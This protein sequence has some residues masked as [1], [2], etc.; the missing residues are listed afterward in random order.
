MKHFIDDKQSKSLSKKIKSSHSFSLSYFLPIN[1]GLIY[2]NIIGYR[3][4]QGTRECPPTVRDFETLKDAEK[5][6]RFS[7]INSDYNLIRALVKQNGFYLEDKHGSIVDINTKK[8]YQFIN[9]SRVSEWELN[10]LDY[11]PIFQMI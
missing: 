2:S 7:E 5:Y 3:V 9:S 1:S 10:Y 6:L 8:K 11:K 4:I